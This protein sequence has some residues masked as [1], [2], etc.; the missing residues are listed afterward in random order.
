[1]LATPAAL[2]TSVRVS[3][4]AVLQPARAPSSPRPFPSV[5][6][7][8]AGKDDQVQ[9]GAWRHAVRS[10]PW[11]R[12]TKCSTVERAVGLQTLCLRW[13]FLSQAQI[14]QTHSNQDK[15]KHSTAPIQRLCYLSGS[16]L[17]FSTAGK[18]K[19]TRNGDAELKNKVSFYA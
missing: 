18:T 14:P 6:L 11:W 16:P 19:D 13:E 1:M 12:R 15:V 2:R 8:N 17:V 7:R 4:W 9:Q 10:F 5:R 3:G